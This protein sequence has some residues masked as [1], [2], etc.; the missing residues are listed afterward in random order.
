MRKDDEKF[1][2]IHFVSFL[3]NVFETLFHIFIVSRFRIE[4]SDRDYIAVSHGPSEGFVSIPA[5][6]NDT[7]CD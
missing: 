4:D 2:K 1:K 7:D 5:V 6:R 3:G